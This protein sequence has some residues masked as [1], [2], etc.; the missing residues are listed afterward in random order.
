MQQQTAPITCL[1]SSCRQAGLDHLTRRIAQALFEARGSTAGHELDDWLKAEALVEMTLSD[2]APVNRSFM[3]LSLSDLG[4]QVPVLRRP[5]V[6][7]VSCP[8]LAETDAAWGNPAE[9]SL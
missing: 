8:W 3:S 7:R 1:P 5:A 9:P 2:L 6:D 4:Q